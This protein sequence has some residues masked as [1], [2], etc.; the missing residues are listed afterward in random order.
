MKA[1]TIAALLLSSAA[2]TARAVGVVDYCTA[3]KPITATESQIV[4]LK[5]DLTSYQGNNCVV[6]PSA[7]ITYDGNNPPSGFGVVVTFSGGTVGNGGSLRVIYPNNNVA[8]A[9]LSIV[10]RIENSEFQRDAAI[11]ISGSFPVSSLI[12]IT[13]NTFDVSAKNSVFGA[14]SGTYITPIAF[15]QPDV[16][17]QLYTG[18]QINILDNVIKVEDRGAD[19][20][21]DYETYGVYVTSNI[22][23]TDGAGLLIRRNNITASAKSRA[24]GVYCPRYFFAV[25]NATAVQISENQLDVTNGILIHS[26]G[27]SSVSHTSNCDISRNQGRL[28]PIHSSTNAIN[29]GPV[30]ITGHSQYNVN[31]NVIVNEDEAGAMFATRIVLA[32]AAHLRN[33]SSFRVGDNTLD[34]KGGSPQIAF[35]AMTQVDDDASITVI[36]NSLQRTDEQPASLSPF[37]FFG[38]AL[39]DRTTMSIS[40]NVLGA[41][42]GNNRPQM[43]AVQSTT[44][45]ISKA[46]TSTFN[47]CHNMW[48]GSY[49]ESDAQV[50]DT[51]NARVRPLV[52]KLS[53]C[54]FWVDTTTTEKPAPTTLPTLP[55]TIPTTTRDDMFERDNSAASTSVLAAAGAAFAAFAAMLL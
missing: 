43:I 12:S 48:Y 36:G 5:D 16:E 52:R 10:M 33:R 38:L 4:T 1:L 44:T 30:N 9:A 28:T 22:Y 14:V 31:N 23:A 21:A 11:Y 3:A 2:L 45:E 8:E 39:R 47:L 53:D 29:L 35:A 32:G 15:G 41:K 25:G 24:V 51:L 19:V 50:A 34:V 49:F 18:S 6:Q 13:G 37:S 46:P 55:T 17:M 20:T 42:N 27:L 7:R 54:P 40:Q 26:P